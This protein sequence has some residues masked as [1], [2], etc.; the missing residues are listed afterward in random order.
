MIVWRRADEHCKSV[1]K[2]TRDFPLEEKFGI[3]SQ[4]RRASLSVVLNIV[5]GL[6][7]GSKKDKIRFLLIAR[8]SLAECAYCSD[9]SNHL[10]YISKEQYNEIESVR[11]RTSYLLQRTIDS[12]NP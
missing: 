3:V 6:A 2:L 8:G 5:E 7:R 12:L 10:G 9:I 4:W 1:Y 11:G